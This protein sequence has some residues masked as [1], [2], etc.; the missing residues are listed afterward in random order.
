MHKMIV[1][2]LPL[3]VCNLFLTALTQPSHVRPIAHAIWHPR[4]DQPAVEAFY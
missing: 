1:L 4:F 2:A 3:T